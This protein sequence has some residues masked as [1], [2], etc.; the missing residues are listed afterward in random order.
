MVSSRSAQTFK[1]KT[2]HA[3][4]NHCLAMIQA[5]LIV[6]AESARLIQPAEGSFYYPA[7]GKNLESFG[8]IAAP[9]NFQP[10]FTK[11]PKLLHPLDQRSQ[12]TTIGPDN[13][14]A[15][16]QANQDFDQALGGIAVLH[17]SGC[18][19]NR[20]NQSQAVHRQV[21]LASR[22][23]F[24]RVVAALSRLV[25]HLDRLAIDDSR[26]RGHLTFF[27]LAH[28]VAQR[29]VNECPG[30]I[31]TPAPKAAIDS[32]PRTKVAR[33]QPPGAAGA[34]HVKHRVDQTPTIQRGRS[35]TLSVSRFWCWN[36]G[37]N[38]LPFF[39]SQIARIT[40]WMRLH[41]SHL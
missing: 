7:L 8:L 10:Q 11:G 12:I 14:Q 9:D 15:P 33:Q 21:A 13:L 16:I 26:R 34:N 2:N 23:L 38:T 20:Q 17:S 5:N 41:P 35:A 6:A 39:I 3:E 1:H 36:K 31:L 40:S 27:G 4:P 19:H 18:D 32:L 30:P 28:V 37:L 22:H 24:S 29:V 25:G